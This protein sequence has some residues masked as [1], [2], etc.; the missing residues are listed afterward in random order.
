MDR[1]VFIIKGY[2]KTDKELA[3]DRYY[4]ESYQNY[5]SSIAGGAYESGDIIYIEEPTVEEVN[6]ILAG[7]NLDYSVIVLI[8]HGAT[9]D[10]KQLFQLNNAEIIR[11]G[12]INPPSSKS[13]FILESCR[14]EVKNILAV[15]LNDKIPKFKYG[16]I[17]RAPIS[18]EKSRELY[19]EQ[20]NNCADGIVV[21][22]AC[23]NTETAKN[24][25]FSLVLLQIGFNWHLE[26]WHHFE[27]LTITKLMPHI[28][29]EVD[30]I[31][32][33]KTGEHQTPE[34]SGALNFPF[35]VSKF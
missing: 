4:S 33:E 29:T 3:L 35:V 20:I 1:K 22:F 2:S 10:D 31:A 17:V 32:V 34:I 7:F 16:G 15:D 27:T 23:S 12:Q 11:P 18:R 14:T 24:F 8:G 13:L 28:A 26:H 19:N 6:N 21:C 5:F 9:Q 25:Y 30:K